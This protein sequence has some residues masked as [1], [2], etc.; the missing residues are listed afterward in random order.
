MADIASPDERAQLRQELGGRAAPSLRPASLTSPQ[1][2]RPIPGALLA[3]LEVR[4]RVGLEPVIGADHPRRNRLQQVFVV[5]IVVAV[6][7]A[8]V[9][10]I[11]FGIGHNL[12]GLVAAIVAAAGVIGAVAGRQ[13]TRAD[14]LRITTDEG[15]LLDRARSWQSQ[16]P[17]T[18]AL[19][20]GPERALLG[21]AVDEVGRIAINP[22]WTSGYLDEHRLAFDLAAELDGLD[23]QLY[24][25][26]S[27]RVAGGADVSAAL[28]AGLDRVVA[29]RRYDAGLAT[30]TAHIVAADTQLHAG[31]AIGE[32][33]GS[34]DVARFAVEGVQ[35]L[36]DELGVITASVDQTAADL[37]RDE[38]S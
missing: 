31:P 7:A 22:A 20:T 10:G 8:V 12:L 21:V 37:R 18:G 24:Q 5:P 23:A 25:V 26:A 36:T 28:D 16:Q 9:A 1:P 38:P 14:P 32:L 33:R 4:R 27:S 6:P 34:V 35:R 15:H 13:W 11:G 2:I 19:N 17:W 3:K 29:L 30:L